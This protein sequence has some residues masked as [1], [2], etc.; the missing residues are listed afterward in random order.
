MLHPLMAGRRDPARQ[1]PDGPRVSLSS[2]R[3]RHP[4]RD[5]DAERY[6]WGVVVVGEVVAS[7]QTATI[8]S[9]VKPEIIL[10]GKIPKSRIGQSSSILDANCEAIRFCITS[11]H[12]ILQ[13]IYNS[14]FPCVMYIINGIFN[15][16]LL[17]VMLDIV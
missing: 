9:Y 3:Y 12:S 8:S 15:V 1:R 6:R 14:Y 13:D 16:L 10:S 2:R 4:H 7:L 17:C 11:K 5:E